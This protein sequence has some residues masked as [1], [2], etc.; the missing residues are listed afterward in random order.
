MPTQTYC[1]R[2]DVEA[3][4]SPL[5]V[6]RSVD[7]DEDGALSPTEEAAI[8]RA[9]ERAANVANAS[10][11]MRYALADLASN[12]WCRDCNAALA[13]YF[14]ATRRGNPAPEHV[15]RQYDSFVH[16]LAEIRAGRLKVPQAA[17]SHE[18]TP[19]VTNF[20]TEL[21]AHRTK[22]RRVPETSTGSAPP[23]EVKS[24]SVED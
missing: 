13:A 4:W 22:V 9:I 5:A 1:T 11:E 2:A 8:D 3:M 15:Q 24:Q 21:A 7:D 20:D 16:D 19:A 18:T 23:G 12:T 17:D 14:L 10:L 6:L